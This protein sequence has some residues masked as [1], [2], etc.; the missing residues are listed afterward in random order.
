M[1]ML[2]VAPESFLDGR[3]RWAE[4]V[5]LVTSLPHLNDFAPTS[6]FSDRHSCLAAAAAAARLCEALAGSA[7]WKFCRT[8]KPSLFDYA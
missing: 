7:G 4:M 5:F 2:A 6:V 8:G 3:R 1:E